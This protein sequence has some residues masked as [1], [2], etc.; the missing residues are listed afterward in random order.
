MPPAS[1]MLGLVV[2][3]S[4]TPKSSHARISVRSAVSAKISIGVLLLVAGDVADRFEVQAFELGDEAGGGFEITADIVRF[5]GF[6]LQTLGADQESGAANRLAGDHVAWL[7][8]D[9]VRPD[10]PEVHFLG[11]LQ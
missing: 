10:K 4:S 9:H 5:A 11:R 2:T 6:G 7:V 8:T 3:P 1:M